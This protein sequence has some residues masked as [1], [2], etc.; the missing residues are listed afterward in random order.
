MISYYLTLMISQLFSC[1]CVLKHFL[2]DSALNTKKKYI[3]RTTLI[4]HVMLG[5]NAD[6]SY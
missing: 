2:T 4:R 5:Q 3:K 1:D 6:N